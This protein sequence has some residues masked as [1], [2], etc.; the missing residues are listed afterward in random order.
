MSDALSS[1]RHLLPTATARQTWAELAAEFRRLPGLSAA[2]VALLV[3][4]SAAGLVAPYVLGRLV[5]DVI[6]ESGTDRVVTWAAVIAAA[7]VVAGAL[8]AAGAA[9]AAR[10]GETVLARLRERVLDRALHLPSATLERAGTGDLVARAGDDVAVVTNAIT[11]V[12]PLMLGALL[13]IVLTAGGLFTLDWRLGLAGLVAA[14][15]YA[16]AM[17]WYLPKSTPYYARERIVTGER[18][19]AMAGALHGA[20]TVR[21]YGTED[22]HVARI[23]DR[24][25]AARDLSLTVFGVFTRFGLRINRAEFI[26]LSS[27]LVV[28]FLLVRADA[29]TVGAA[30]AAALYF[31][32]LFN[33]IGLILMEFDAV[34]QARASLARLVG[35]ASLPAV[36]VPSTE[37]DVLDHDAAL[38]VTVRQHR[39]E[40]GP[41]VLA[42][43]TL[44]LAP[45]ERVA[46]V[47]ASGAGKSTLAGI[48]AGIIPASD[49]DARLRG[50]PLADLGE[51]RVR[52]EI[53]L[54]SQEVHVFAGPLADDL[55]LAR[56]DA[57]DA[58]IEKALDRVGAT[59]WLRTLP[60]GLATHVGEGG[61][62]LT[63]AQAQQLALARLILADPAVAVLDEATAEAG[64]AGARDLDRAAAAATEGRTTLIVA[65]RLVQAAD[66][67]RIIVLDHG[68]I[69]E[70]GTHETLLAAGGRYAHLWQ[71]WG[72]P[73]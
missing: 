44:R 61:H 1:T 49:G 62:R 37:L 39:Y 8:T 20:A 29:I 63:A 57:D 28:G 50:V 23:A 9:V 12:G 70:Q 45:G 47:G 27:V 35:V 58:D 56:P 5:D 67:D 3:A 19:Q 64:S 40:D 25:A 66:A 72:G 14:P 33:P 18:A 53:A 52:K 65:H 22:A 68:R 46:L 6:A 48:A 43:V 17:R 7:A 55:R 2:A 34:M 26:G 71:S 16:L 38:A 51:I 59:G 31:H 41:V 21:A 24:S 15:A 30:T 69:V 4:A 54:V 73:R 32:R 60:D 42:D 36:A 11:G 13:T 10:L